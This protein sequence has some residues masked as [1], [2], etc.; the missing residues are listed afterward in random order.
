[1]A[2]GGGIPKSD[3]IVQECAAGL[4]PLRRSGD[5]LA[6]A[7]PPLIRGGEVD[8]VDLLQISRI[9]RVDQSETVASQWAD[10]G[11]GWIAVMLKDP[12]A[13]LA[14]EPDFSAAEVFD[15]GVV[16]FHQ[17]GVAGLTS[18]EELEVRAFFRNG[19][20]AAEDPATGSLNA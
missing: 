4:V 6:F 14:L 9:L 7:A 13:V 8:D 15:I 10:N 19:G 20:Y 17:V 5:R 18:N 12:D 16:G 1:M 11:P 2:R 3:Q